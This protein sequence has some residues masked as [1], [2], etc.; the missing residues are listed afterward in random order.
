MAS[1]VSTSDREEPLLTQS[2]SSQS[3]SQDADRDS[4]SSQLSGT[5][6]KLE[7]DHVL[8][9]RDVVSTLICRQSE[10]KAVLH[11]KGDLARK[12]RSLLLEKTRQGLAGGDVGHALSILIA[13]QD[14]MLAPYST[15]VTTVGDAVKGAKQ[16]LQAVIA[17]VRYH[18]RFQV[19]FV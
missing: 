18:D 14:S 6:R 2:P 9:L 8:K 13:D 4:S 12:L 19:N 11:D 16:L 10:A 1:P 7:T 17:Y 15:A 3:T 5:K